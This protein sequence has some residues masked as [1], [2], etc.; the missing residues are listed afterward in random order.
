MSDEEKINEQEEEDRV[1]V[2]MTLSINAKDR[3][4]RLMRQADA[5]SVGE[6]V[7]RMMGPFEMLLGARDNDLRL[8]MEEPEG[9]QTRFLLL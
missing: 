1:R 2:S 6:L 4:L 7:R 8:V 5:D 9:E 3:L